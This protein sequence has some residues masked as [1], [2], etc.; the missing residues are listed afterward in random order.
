MDFL[1]PKKKRSHQIR[2]VIGYVLMAVALGIATLILVFATSGYDLDPKTGDIVQNGLVFV[3]ARPER[4]KVFLDG[5]DKGQTDLRLVIPAG[6]HNLELKRPGYRTW[7]RQFEA[8]GSTVKRFAYPFLFPEKLVTKDI[9]IYGTAPGL[10]T[11]SPDRRWLLVQQPNSIT[12]FE[13]IDLNTKTNSIT[14]ISL[15]SDL[16]NPQGAAHSLE[17]IEWSS[18]NRR[19]LIKHKFE[20]GHEFVIIDRE[21][22]SESLNINKLF[23]VPITNMTLR[24]KKFDEYYLHEAAG[25]ILRRADARSKQATTILTEVINFKPH[26][27]DLILYISDEKTE[28]GRVTAKIWD[29]QKIY[30]LRQIPVSKNYLIDIARFDNK[31]LLAAGGD[32][33][34]KVYIY[35]DPFETLKRKPAKT[36]LPKSVLRVPGAQ[37]VSFST[38]ARFISVQ[39]GSQ[40]AVYD[41]ENSEQF[42]Y[43]TKLP[44]AINQKAVWMDGHR[45]SLIS[46]NKAVIFDFDGANQQILAD[47]NPAHQIFYD[48]DYTSMFTI[49]T[50]RQVAL[51][52]ALIRTELKVLNP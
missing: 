22:P 15:P 45:L 5:K 16:L 29:N 35:R 20:S 4:A 26:G 36:A 21:T 12:N 19:V 43:D 40:F 14:T 47:A 8:E 6:K 7:Q 39:G 30:A 33:E 44:I 42:H 46:N 38:N 32:S 23:Q 34:Q 27:A 52:P 31:W 2:L 10:S 11:S 9:E 28:S 3:D 1:D 48:R 17:F 13:V 50:S 24:D 18:D 51:K 49:A 41:A 25:G 37:F